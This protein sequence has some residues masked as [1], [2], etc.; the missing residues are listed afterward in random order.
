MSQIFDH[1]L[2]QHMRKKTFLT[3]IQSIQGVKLNNYCKVLKLQEKQ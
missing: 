2:P 3:V 1:D